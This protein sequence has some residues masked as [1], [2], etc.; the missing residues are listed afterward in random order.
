MLR[1]RSLARPAAVA[2]LVLAT[3]CGG[4][5]DDTDGGTSSAVGGED[6]TTTAA[7]AA[8]AT[9]VR[10]AG[11]AFKPAEV[12]VPVGGTVT[13]EFDDGSVAHNVVFEDGPKSDIETEGTFEHTFDTAG[14]FPYV[15][16]LHPTMKGTVTV[17]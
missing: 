6:P 7:G 14:S 5:G 4:G 8:G 13:W 17:K 1:L 11:L 12:T 3:A 9:R 16:T 10:V 2:L 15:C